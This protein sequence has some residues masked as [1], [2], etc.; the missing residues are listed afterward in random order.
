MSTKKSDQPYRH[1]TLI[2]V[3]EQFIIFNDENDNARKQFIEL[4]ENTSPLKIELPQEI[5]SVWQPFENWDFVNLIDLIDESAKS[6]ENYVTVTNNQKENKFD[7]FNRRLYLREDIE[8][9]DEDILYNIQRYDLINS[10]SDADGVEFN[11]SL[12][13]MEDWLMKQWQCIGKLDDFSRKVASRFNVS[14]EEILSSG[15]RDQCVLICFLEHLKKIGHDANFDLYAEAVLHID[16]DITDND[17]ELM[18]IGS[19][20]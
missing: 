3:A 10:L 17:D 19:I 14:Y 11:I 12:F 9:I 8:K 7:C 5:G 6:I 1:A 15:D 16:G 4:V 2:V 18:K 20:N 13:I